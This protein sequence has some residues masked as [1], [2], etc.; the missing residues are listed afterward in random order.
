[1]PHSRPAS[2]DALAADA[3][4][5]QPFSIPLI[6]LALILLGVYVAVTRLYDLDR[7]P[8]QHDESM[9]AYYS[10]Q[11]LENRAYDYANMEIMHGP[12]LEWA[13]AGVFAL[14]GDSEA[15]MRLFPALCGIGILVLVFLMRQGLGRNGAYFALLFLAISPTVTFFARYIRNDTPFLFFGTAI[16]YFGWLYHRRRRVPA[17]PGFMNGLFRGRSI[18]AALLDDLAQ[19]WPLI[20]MFAAIGLIM[21]IKETWISF[22]VLLL[23]F[24]LG[25]CIHAFVKR[26][27][28][29]TSPWVGDV[30]A[31]VLRSP[32]SVSLGILLAVNIILL[33][34]TSFWKFPAEKDGLFTAIHYWLE[35]NKKQRIG[36]QFHFHLLHMAIYELPFL[37]FWVVCV[38][39]QMWPRTRGESFHWP[40]DLFL[41]R[42]LFF[43]WL[44]VSLFTLIV[45]T[46]L[47]G[48]PLWRRSLTPWWEERAHMQMVFHVWL[49]IQ[50]ALVICIVG[51]NHLNRGRA[52]H[53]WVDY[54]AA[55]SFIGYSYAGEKV[56]WVGLHI[57]IPM[58]ISCGLYAEMA[59]RRWLG[60]PFEGE[61][62]TSPRASRKPRSK[63]QRRAVGDP[64][65]PLFER[66][67]RIWAIA[68]RV[69][70]STF[71]IVGI[72]WTVRLTTLLNFKNAGQA[73]ERHTYAASHQEFYDEMRAVI[74]EAHERHNGF[75]TTFHHAGQV[76]WPLTWT[77]RNY[78]RSQTGLT[79]RPKFIIVDNETWNTLRVDKSLYDWKRVKFRHY[80]QPRQLDWDAMKRIGLLLRD[81]NDLDP[82]SLRIR[83]IGRR[84][85]IAFYR[86]MSPA[87]R[88]DE[89]REYRWDHLGGYDAYVGRLRNP[90]P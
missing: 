51:W 14:F 68:S 7:K 57:V 42:G 23:T 36:G 89:E 10:W 54:W 63:K 9:F 47:N 2:T 46:G 43:T 56:P 77:F 29:E 69:G 35:E 41:R 39:K 52:F 85:W 32:V 34:Y 67:R 8:V 3:G 20:C 48:T 81:P 19:G 65:D 4:R 24:G 5:A 25:C 27:P 1:M 55:G 64:A 62:E 31:A 37:V 70:L 6:T 60:L 28:A 15:T 72:V 33:L 66:W 58:L 49:F 53:A 82:E 40:P 22:F 50:V 11:T 45:P 18:L 80:W 88:N 71:A 30:R 76:G 38:V 86:A 74:A 16:V 44:A 84:E 59:R 17:E 21:C 75:N 83:E 78:P 12:L 61:I 90:A 26:S 13:V 87:Y 73:I 79:A